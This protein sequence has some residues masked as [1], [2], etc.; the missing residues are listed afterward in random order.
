MKFINVILFLSTILLFSCATPKPVITSIA[1]IDNQ[2]PVYFSNNEASFTLNGSEL[3]KLNT[4]GS[5][6]TKNSD[7]VEIPGS[8]AEKDEIFN[9]PFGNFDYSYALE[10]SLS[11]SSKYLAKAN[12][13]FSLI[14][15]SLSRNMD[16]DIVDLSDIEIE[17]TYTITLPRLEY[18]DEKYQVPWSKIDDCFFGLKE[19]S[20]VKI[21]PSDNNQTLLFYKKHIYDFSISPTENYALVFAEDSL[22][23]FDLK[24]KEINTIYVPGKVL[25][26]N[27]KYVRAYCWYEDETKVTFAEGWK[28]FVYNLKSKQLDKIDAG[29]KVFSADWIDNNQILIVT[30]DYPSDMSAVQSNKQFKIF[31]YSFLT[32][33]LFKIHERINHEPFSIKPRISPSKKLIL[34][35][36]KK[37]SGPYQVK[38]M[39]LDG[40]NENIIAEGYLPFWGK[41]IK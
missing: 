2:T 32:D 33:E 30:G 41:P 36:E 26:I 16:V 9:H 10:P 22:F 25:G 1:E 15:I 28:V 23:L 29:A 8:T 21:N 3:Y 24:E 34:F 38:L 7:G 4:F 11:T 31:K 20:L 35:S 37:V 6:T 17:K 39:T 14:N 5:T 13:D 40:Q 27:R 19:D 18:R 12:D